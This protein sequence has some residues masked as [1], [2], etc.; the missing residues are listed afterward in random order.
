M[1]SHMFWSA[2][3]HRADLLQLREQTQELSSPYQHEE[4]EA[5]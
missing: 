2:G 1:E 3:R 4:S 5:P